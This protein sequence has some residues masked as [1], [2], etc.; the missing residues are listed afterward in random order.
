M[1]RKIE[2][3]L[4]GKILRKGIAGGIRVTGLKTR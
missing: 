4:E 2:E 3:S 1:E